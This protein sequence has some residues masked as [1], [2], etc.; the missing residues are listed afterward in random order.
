MI[1]RRDWLIAFAVGIPLA[2]GVILISLAIVSL[3]TQT[4][5]WRSVPGF[6]HCPDELIISNGEEWKCA[7]FSITKGE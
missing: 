5:D 7:P 2:V 4:T 1:E 3:S 6:P